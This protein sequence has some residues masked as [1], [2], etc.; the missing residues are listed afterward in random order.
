MFGKTFDSRILP[1]LF[2]LANLFFGFLSII[3]AFD[4]QLRMSAGM[5]MFSV[6]MDSLDGKVAR[7]LKASSD[8]GKELDSL[9]DVISFGLAPGVLIYV[10]VYHNYWP[11]WGA[12]ISGFFT[13]CGA[14]RL[15]RFNILSCTDYFVGVP[16]TFAGG[17]MALLLLFLD[18]IPWEAYPVTMFIL[19]VLMVSSLQVPKLGK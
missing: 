13:I 4:H 2:T 16:I 7:K 12:W 5:I 17:F 18:R 8:F 1:C 10:F 6:L 19:A 11:F 3:F 9:S 15:A 14:L